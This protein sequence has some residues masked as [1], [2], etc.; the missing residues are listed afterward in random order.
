ME[1]DLLMA[2]EGLK[3]VKRKGWVESGIAD[4]ESVADH[5][6]AVALIVLLHSLA[7]KDI[8]TGKAVTM[9]LIHDLA[10]A[11][12]GDVTPADNVPR[13]L[14]RAREVEALE[15]LFT[16][17]SP[18]EGE[19]LMAMT[20]ELYEGRT[21]EARLVLDAD[22]FERTVQ[23]KLYKDRGEDVDRF[24]DAAGDLEETD[25]GPSIRKFLGS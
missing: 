4:P 3:G 14:Q 23:A 11:I 19:G 1:M 8:D 6:C 22:V 10:E 24:I 21:P 15:R 7:R 17:L 12:V 20:R 18:A 25:F 5:T 9:A 2:I 16:R 13:E